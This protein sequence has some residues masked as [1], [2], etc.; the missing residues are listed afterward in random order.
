MHK[1]RIAHRDIKPQNIGFV[2]RLQ[3]WCYIDFG[4]SEV[5]FQQLE[6]IY[7]IK[8]TKFYLPENIREQYDKKKY[9][10]NQNLF[11]NDKV[12]LIKTLKKV[13]NNNKKT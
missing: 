7:E 2:E 10:T 1:F 3:K 6:D 5:Y 13:T 4:E 8:G 9:T 12:A 11:N